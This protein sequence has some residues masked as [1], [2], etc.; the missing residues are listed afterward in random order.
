MIALATDFPG[1][2]PGLPNAESNWRP[3]FQ[4]PNLTGTITPF[5]LR[6]EAFHGRRVRT[7]EEAY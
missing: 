7:L 3:C 5:G 6:A 4:G 1:T 2:P